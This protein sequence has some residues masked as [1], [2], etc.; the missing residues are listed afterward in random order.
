MKKMHYAWKI[1]FVCCCISGAVSG[2]VIHCRGIFFAPA[3]DGI[4]VSPTTYATYLTC[5]GIVGVLALPL[6]TKLFREWP[7]K[8]VLLL[9]LALFCGG[10]V[11][12][13]FAQEMWQCYIIGGIQGSVSSFMTI[14]P[15]SY[16]IKAWFT[17]RRGFAIGF[18]TMMSGALASIMNIVIERMINTIGWRLSY[19]SIGS[20]AFLVGAI[21]ILA[22]LVRTPV[23]L[24]MEPYGGPSQNDMP[25]SATQKVALDRNLLSVFL[26]VSFLTIIAYM[27]SGYGQHLSN[28]AH[29]LGLPLSTGAVLVSIYMLGNVGGKLLSGL[30]NDSIGIY[31]TA[32]LTLTSM[33]VGFFILLQQTDNLLLLKIAAAFCGQATAF[34]AVQIP[35]LLGDIFHH[36][37]E[38]DTCLSM[39]VMMGTLTSAVNNTLIAVL[40]N[41]NNSY[42]LGQTLCSLSLI[43][44]AGIVF[45][46]YL[47]TKKSV[48]AIKKS[49]T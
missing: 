5:G 34:I 41:K 22:F 17:K 12:H 20:I 43:A 42:A 37:N 31:R 1:L 29:D 25:E 21:P 18:A 45:C 10:T 33:S 38:Y 23:E 28:F 44:C 19:I 46:L 16:I 48:Y 6:I 11:A 40:Y 32:I 2:M 4:G 39:V 47:K 3:A 7:I 9:Y 13:G 14:Y 27:A 15:I 24:G 8:R 49:N 30:L 36:K 26:P 35:L